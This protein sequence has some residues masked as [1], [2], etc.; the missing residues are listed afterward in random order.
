MTFGEGDF[1]DAL[2]R[3]EK[4]AD[5]H[6]SLTDCLSINAMMVAGITDVL[7]TD[8]HFHQAGLN[9]LL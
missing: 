2:L 3:Y 8:H 9:V 1:E 6:W 5:K 4:Y 7:T